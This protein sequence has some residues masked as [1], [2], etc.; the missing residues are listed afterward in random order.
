[1]HESRGRFLYA[2]TT[3]PWKTP[4][5][6]APY[7]LVMK[8]ISPNANQD[9]NN[10]LDHLLSKA[11]GLTDTWTDWQNKCKLTPTQLCQQQEKK[12]KRKN[13]T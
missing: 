13:T 2:R 7:K 6:L 5:T 1:M 12:K 4:L 3:E 10:S 11:T 8:A 9:Q